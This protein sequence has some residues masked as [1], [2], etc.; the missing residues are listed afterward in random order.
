MSNSLVHVSRRPEWGARKRM[1]GVCRCWGVPW[2]MR[3]QPRSWQWRLREQNHSPGF[4]RSRNPHWSTPRVNRQIGCRR[5][6]SNRGTSPAL[7][8]FPLN[9]FK[10]ALTLFSKSFSSFPRGTCLLLMSHM[11]LALD[12]IYHPI[13]A[14]FPNNPTRRRHL[15]VQQGPSTTGLLPSSAPPSRGLRPSPLLR[16]LLQTTIRRWA[17]PGL[18]A[19]TRGILVSFFSSAYWYA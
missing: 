8:R 6:T 7:I 11:Y 10:Q 16:M 9:N 5:S 13:R 1:P 4:S 2:G 18:L 17:I 15:M 19:V 3:Y 12:G 14:A